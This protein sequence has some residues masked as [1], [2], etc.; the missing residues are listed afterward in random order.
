VAALVFPPDADGGHL[1]RARVH[2]GA[3][4][5]FPRLPRG[6]PRPAR[7]ARR[8][9]AAF[10]RLRDSLM[11]SSAPAAAPRCAARWRRRTPRRSR[12]WCAPDRPALFGTFHFGGSDLLG[13][14]LSERG[15]RVS[16]IRLR[17]GNSDRHAPARRAVCR[18]GLVS[19]DQRPRQ[20]ALRF[21]G[22]DRGRR[23][24]GAE[25]RPAGVQRERPSRSISSA[26]AACSRSPS[27]TWPSCSTG[28]WCS[29]RR[30][31]IGREDGLR[32]FASPVFTPDPAA[33]REANTWAARGHFQAV[34]TQLETLV[35]QHPS[36]GLTSCP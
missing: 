33:D 32:V 13:Y 21:E 1:G 8:G 24:A 30:C 18:A 7:P 12:R 22:G 9:L 15:R 6:R 11:L 5:A 34:L 31:R 27:T 10:F 4:R 29:A 19:L 20:P 2:A 14:L 28:R 3:A 25:V 16:I 35:R 17:V 36:S 23:I 26:R